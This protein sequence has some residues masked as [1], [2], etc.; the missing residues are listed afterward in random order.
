MVYDSHMSQSS[1]TMIVHNCPCI[2]SFVNFLGQ[3]SPTIARRWSATYENQAL[4]WFSYIVIHRRYS[5]SGD[6]WRVN[7]FVLSYKLATDNTSPMIPYELRHMKTRLYCP[8]SRK[9]SAYNKDIVIG[10]HIAV[11][12]LCIRGHFKHSVQA[13]KFERFISK[14]LLFFIHSVLFSI[15]V[16]R[17]S[18]FGNE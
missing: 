17:C 14:G 11:N 10:M 5:L 16:V 13:L 4:G 18:N 7:C 8:R 12:I 2:K 15:F 1:A 3:L 6:H 9:A